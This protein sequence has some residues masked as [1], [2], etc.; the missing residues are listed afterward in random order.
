[1]KKISTSL[2]FAF[3][4]LSNINA[5]IKILFDATKAETAGNADW[6]IDADL[7]NIGYSA[8]PANVGGGNEANPQRIATPAQSGI[9]ASTSESYWKGGLSYWA[10]DCVKKGYQ[11]ETLPYNGSITYGN[12]AN[13][14]DL[15]NYKIFVVVEPN[16]V[17]L[18]QK[19]LH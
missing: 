9:T 11:V 10:V 12:A 4:F 14:Q 17:F 2:F 13:T 5:Q 19:K 15:S 7:F 1:M 3:I 18:Q 16:I 6:I 8:G